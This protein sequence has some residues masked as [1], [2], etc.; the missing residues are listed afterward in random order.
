[1][2]VTT[3]QNKIDE[4][5]IQHSGLDQKR[6]YLGISAIGKCPRQVVRDHLHGKSELT[7]RDHQMCYAGYFFEADLRNRIGDMG[8]KV[9]RVGFE[10]V[11]D[12]D[13][14]L[15][16]HIDGELFDSELLECKSVN[17]TKFEKVKET[18]LALTEHF[19]QVQLYMKYGPWKQCWLIYVNR[20]TLEHH[21]V[22]VGY[23]HTQAIKYE[24]KAQRMLAHIDS[25]ILPACEC[26]RC[27][28]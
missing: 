3:F 13:P 10:V 5:L 14:R 2:D 22:K 8:F 27:K 19:A 7:L 17:R 1:M 21:V 16:G 12:F 9:T 4:H 25:G 26:H 6:D 18:H 28:E 20:E 24:L 11:A 23:L 15:R